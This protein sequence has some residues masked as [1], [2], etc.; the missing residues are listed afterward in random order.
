MNR[1]ITLFIGLFLTVCSFA[2]QKV[3]YDNDSRWF[4]GINAGS[5]W[6]TADVAK[7]NEWGWGLTL[8]KSFNYNYGRVF[9]FDIRGRY[10]TGDWLGQNSDTTHVA[11]I[12]P[13]NTGTTDYNTAYGYAVLNHKVKVHELSLELVIHANNLR[14]KTGWDPYIFG[15]IGYTWYRTKGDLING[16]TGGL[17]GYDSLVAY[18][19][20]TKPNVEN[21]LDGDYETPLNGSTADTYSGAFMPSLGFG[22]GYQL[23][24]RFSM[25]I[26]HKTTFTLDDVFDGY[27]NS[28]G[29][30]ANDWYHYTGIYMRFQIR[31]HA[32]VEEE[33]TNSLEQV[34]NYDQAQNNLP[35]TVDF[36]NPSTSGTTVSSANYVIRAN[37]KNVPGSNNVIFRQNGNYNTNFTFN[38]STQSF[39]SIV[40]LTPGQNVFELTGTN[41]YGS[42]QEQTVIIYNRE[43][44]NPPIVT[45]V[46]PAN[47]PATV[48]SPQY[49][50]VAS[51]LNVTQQ[52]QVA[53]TLNGQAVSNFIFNSANNNVTVTLNLQVG[54]N[55]VTTSGT[56]VYGSDQESTTIIYNPVQTEQPPVVYFVDPNVNPYT[57]NNATFVIN[58]DVLN[59][60]G[61]QN[62]TF[63]QNGSVNQNFTYNAQTDDFQSTVVL[64][65]GQ[66]VFEII[67]TNSAGSAQA[68]TIII[69][70]RPAPKPPIVTITNPATNP[71][72]V[73]NAIFNLVS[74]V[75]NVSQASQVSVKLNGQSIN[76]NYNNATSGVTATLNL[77]VGTNVVSVTGTNADGTDAKQTTLIYRPIQTVQPPVVQFTA[78]SVDPFT[79]NQAN[80][81]VVATVL[82]V[83]DISGVNVNVNGSNITNFTFV[84]SQVSFPLTLIEGAN[85]ITITGTNTAGTD[86]EP[87]TI[88]YT[89]PAPAQPPVVSYVD[90][91]VNPTTVYAPTYNV[92]ARVRYVTGASQIVL[93]INGQTSTNFTYST[94]SELMDFTTALVPGANIVNIIATNTAGQDQEATTIIYRL[95]NPTVPP[96]VTITN[97]MSNPYTSSTATTPIAA[98]VLNVDG[99]QNIQVLVNGSVFTNF[100]YNTTNKQLNFTMN[101]N[102]GANSLSIVATNTAGQASDTRTINYMREQVQVPPVVTFIN[103]AT[104][105]TTVA[106]AGFVMK[107]RVLYVNGAA[108]IVVMQNGQVISPSLWN[109]DAGTKEVT[110]NT[111]LNGGNNVFTVTGTNTAGSNSASTNVIYQIPVVVCDKP[112]V[113]YVLPASSGTTVQAAQTMITAT[114]QHITS[115]NQVQLLVNGILQSTGSFNAAAQSFSKQISLNEGQNVIEF[116]ATN[117]CGSTNASTLMTYT[118]VAAPC[119]PPTVQRVDPLNDVLVVEVATI[120]VKAAVTNVTQTSQIAV[121]VNGV[122]VP[123]N[124]DNATHLVT[125]DVSL[126][127]GENV[128][129]IAVSTECGKQTIDWRV[130][131]KICS[132]PTVVLNSSSVANGAT[133]YADNLSLIALVTGVSTDADIT[134]TL[135]NQNIGFVYNVQTGVLNLT[136]ALVVGNNSF[137]IKV[138]NDCGEGFLKFGVVRRSQPTQNPPTVA[139]TNPGTTPTS[140][141]QPGMTVQVATT[142]IATS[143][144]LSIT[145]NGVQTNFDFNSST[146]SASFNTNFQVG[147]NVI[148]ATAVN[149]AGTATDSKTVIYTA[150]VVVQ[151]PVVTFTNPSA[152]PA[153]LPRGAQTITG[154]VTHITNANQVSIL[155]NGS[156]VV[157]NSTISGG[158]LSF[159]FVINVI[160]T[161]VNIPIV[162]TATNDGGTDVASCAVSIFNADSGNSNSNGE[163]ESTEGNENGNSNNG[164]GTTN[165]TRTPT[166]NG[167]KSSGTVKPVTKPATTTTTT[168]PATTTTVKPVLKP[169]TTVK[170]SNAVKVPAVIKP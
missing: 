51:V 61:A 136:S 43:Q 130:N 167:G 14:A 148:V 11:Y 152:C 118:P 138:K 140:V 120:S 38:P 54:T 128:I 119:L 28:S 121:V 78:P 75:L 132:K 58:A 65:P 162:V 71:Q 41:T 141:S 147:A 93:Q 114:I 87:Q 88:I 81:T 40:T 59:V 143:S 50:L 10:L 48:Q 161:T 131:R 166:T 149:S 5:T 83:T 97:P 107:A 15:G 116:I 84:N 18:N 123:F 170:D 126:N 99:A 102:S 142:N 91:V 21:M 115:A 110:F 27:V 26:E 85:V 4:W 124:F 96:V 42:D 86:S 17:Y 80:Y 77:V 159:S 144:Q 137:T 135:N 151:V 125:A 35:P 103:P 9:S 37:I 73:N 25:G 62:I 76:F 155:Y 74:T 19:Q 52:S 154:T 112:V 122:N 60:A 134:V 45:Y 79:T 70:N 72:E 6:T 168:K 39:E 66:N 146:G 101:L 22:L 127:E 2:Q 1:I 57:T 68:S 64:N 157:F 150:P 24:P 117:A 36:T 169:T 31:D 34:T 56:N 156:N 8:G 105:G 7:K 108:Q 69:Y 94:S 47:S 111:T 139:I 23:R 106:T 44:Q 133:T 113:S 82:N 98:T 104:G 158:V 100:T 12:S 20:L 109:F 53:M 13:L 29:K 164:S 89:K 145:V 32:N 153:L 55:I 49:N 3:D 90:P 165:D 92:R 163:S 160:P 46:N 33:N 63:K 30:Y 67:G 95:P 16:A 129:R